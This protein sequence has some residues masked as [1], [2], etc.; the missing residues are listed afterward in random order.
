M[1]LVGAAACSDLLQRRAQCQVA[2]ELSTHRVSQILRLTHAERQQSSDQWR[3]KPAQDPQHENDKDQ[4]IAAFFR[5]H[6]RGCDRRLISR[7][8]CDGRYA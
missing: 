1:L 2:R 3:E 4:R 5:R 6:H 7:R 8:E